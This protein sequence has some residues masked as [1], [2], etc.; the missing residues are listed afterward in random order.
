MAAPLSLGTVSHDNAAVKKIT[1]SRQAA[2]GVGRAAHRPA[3]S[4]A[5]PIPLR[6]PPSR[7]RGPPPYCG[8]PGAALPTTR[9]LRRAPATRG[10]G[11]RVLGQ[12]L[13]ASRERHRDRQ[14]P[15][16]QRLQP[17]R[18]GRHRGE[19]LP[20]VQGRPRVG[21]HGRRW[22][23]RLDPAPVG[24]RH[25]QPGGRPADAAQRDPDLQP[26]LGLLHPG[27]ER[28]GQPGRRADIYVTDFERPASPPPARARPPPRQSP[29]P[30]ASSPA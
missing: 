8:Y 1:A 17:Q 28:R 12:Q 16:R 13:P 21:G 6:P 26:G 9:P 23:D 7:R 20:G 10:R 11:L 15:G 19:H 30:A 25:R 5:R 29:R 2:K 27:A 14:L 4:P 18:G 3:A 22:P 24:V